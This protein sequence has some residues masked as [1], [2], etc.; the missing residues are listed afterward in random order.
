M[1]IP[2]HTVFYE[3]LMNNTQTE[4][5]K[6]ASFLIGNDIPCSAIRTQPTMYKLHSESLSKY[7]SNWEE[8]KLKLQGTPYYWM[9][10]GT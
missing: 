5:C 7:I 1:R 8:I 2:S 9:T 3:D 6:T 4:L 10:E